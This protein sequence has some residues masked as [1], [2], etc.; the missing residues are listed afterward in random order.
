[1]LTL[2]SNQKKILL[3]LVTGLSLGLSFSPRQSYRVLKMFGR[4]WKEID[5][6]NLTRSLKKL[7]KEKLL[8][9]KRKGEYIM[10]V[11]TALGK[12]RA[13]LARLELFE[14]ARPKKWDKK[15]RI[16]LFDIPEEQRIWRNVLRAQLKRLQ[17]QKLQ[18]SVFV[19]PF[20]CMK[21]MKQLS[22]YYQGAQYIRFIEATHI[23]NESELKKR[24]KL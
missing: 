3:L 13:S 19:H 23:D 9:M 14:I 17:F 2:G 10:P 22:D 16:V 11:L 15:W 18:E 24:F 8:V 21:E 5:R 1:M 6:Q 7:E 4:G 12:K 20:N